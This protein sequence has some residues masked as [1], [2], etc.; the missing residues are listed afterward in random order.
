MSAE[1]KK[2]FKVPRPKIPAYYIATKN[3]EICYQSDTKKAVVAW[4]LAFGASIWKV[5]PQIRKLR[6]PAESKPHLDGSG[7]CSKA[8]CHCT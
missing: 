4:K 3:G 6:I 7:K 1:K 2:P 8:G 5:T